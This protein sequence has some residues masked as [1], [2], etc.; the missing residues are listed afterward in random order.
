MLSTLP[1]PAIIAHRGYCTLAPENTLSAFDLAIRHNADGIELD[2]KLSKDGRVVVIHDLT[3]GR[4]TNF[5]G[6]VKSFTLK[7]L[8][9]MDAGSHFDQKF[10]GEKIP[11]LDVVLKEFGDKTFLNI[12]LTNYSHP[13]NNLPHIVAQMLL[14][15]GLIH[16][17]LISS[18]NPIALY[19]IHRILP[20][21]SLGFLIL[22]GKKGL[23]ARIIANFL[24]PFDSLNMEVNDV[25]K[26]I[27]NRLHSKKKKLFVYTVNRA[28]DIRKM[29]MYG[30]DGIITDD[31]PLV[32][33]ILQD[34]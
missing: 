30:V 10:K 7:E 23:L 32:R 15:E 2:A 22:S 8:Q 1:T 3:V 13:L 14:S 18:F 21:V 31:P 33:Q 12:E 25:S 11:S 24:V 9:S 19:R 27:V 5:R 16:N 4:T 28:D 17:I 29:I 6:P 34:N 26:D 20:D